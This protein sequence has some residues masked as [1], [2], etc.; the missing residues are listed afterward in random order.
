MENDKISLVTVC[1]EAEAF[2]EDCIQSVLKQDYPNI[3]YIIIDGGSSDGTLKIIKKYENRIS[4]WISEADEGLYDAMNKGINMASGEVVGFLHADDLYEHISVI[5][6]VM[7][8]FQDEK[9][10]TVYGDLVYVEADNTD[11]ITRY[12]PAQDFH[13][14]KFR[15][16]LMPP[17]PTFFVRK[18]LYEEFGGFDMSYRICADF[19]L[20]VRILYREKV[21]SA[22]LPEVLVRMRNG[23]ISTSSI[24]S[25]LTIN[26]E[27]LKACKKYGLN[28]NLLLIYSKYFTKVSQLFIR[29]ETSI[30]HT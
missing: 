12:Y 24:K 26:Q 6:H 7:G 23:G 22:Y 29:P 20:M 9:I 8:A 25:T 30:V 28:T 14:N 10:G 11:Q 27:M 16:G 3:E 18:S 17:H 13:I 5:S 21:A 15:K 1:F 2:L 19:D 4:K